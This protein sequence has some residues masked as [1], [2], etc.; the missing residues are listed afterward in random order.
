M[1]SGFLRFLAAIVVAA[2]IIESNRHEWDCYFSRLLLMNASSR[3]AVP[4]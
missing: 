3:R 1:F 2:K 4:G